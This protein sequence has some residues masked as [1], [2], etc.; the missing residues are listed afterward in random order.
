MLPAGVGDGTVSYRQSPQVLLAA[1]LGLCW[2]IAG[3]QPASLQAAEPRGLRKA[4]S[5]RPSGFRSVLRAPLP[6]EDDAALHDIQFVGDR[7]GWAVGDR[8]VIWKTTDG[9]RSWQLVPSPVSCPLRSICFL[10][11]RVGW[12][13]G[14]GTLPYTRVGY[15]VLLFTR[16]GGQTW[17]ALA[18]QELP[19]LSHVQF[20]G[21]E[22]GVAVGES[23]P[24]YP[25][26]VLRT[27]DGG[28]NWQPVEGSLQPGW[29]TAAFLSPRTGIVA[30]IQ[31]RVGFA[32]Q[33][34]LMAPQIGELGLRCLRG[35][36]LESDRS[37]WLV[38][39]GGL[40]LKTISNGAV[41]QNPPT[42]LPEHLS[43]V[44]DFRAVA[45][46]GAKVWVA[47]RPGSLIW[48]SP[49]GG[50][51]W[52][53]QRTGQT[54]PI[55]RLHFRNETHGWACGGMGLILTTSDGGQ[56]W[57]AVRGGGRHAALLSISARP[58]RVSFPLLAREG[59]EQGYRVTVLVPARHDTGPDGYRALE[60]D[61]Q[62][63]EAV[64]A[65]GGAAAEIGWQFPVGIPGLAHN[66]ERLIT[67]WNS[68]TEGRLRDVF[69]GSLVSHIR[70]WRPE[71]VVLHQP[72]ADD[73]PAQVIYEAALQ[74]VNLAGDATGFIEQTELAGLEPW[75][76]KKVYVQLPDGSTGDVHIP[77]DEHL[78]RWNRTVRDGAAAG[79]S[80]L[81]PREEWQ[82][83]GTTHAAWQLRTDR[84]AGPVS[85][86]GL[87]A[88]AGRGGDFF[89]GLAIAPGSASRR[90]LLPIDEDTLERSLA[91]ARQ[92]RNVLAIAEQY[93]EQPRYAAQMVAHLEQVTR[94][95]SRERAALQL[96]RLGNGYRERSQWELV[97]AT[98]MELVEKYPE[99]PVAV[100]AMH[101]LFCFWAG[102]EP[103]YQRIR[104]Q[105][106]DRKTLESN[107]QLVTSSIE[108]AIR[109]ARTE[110]ELR[111]G[112]APDYGPDPLSLIGQNG[113]N[114][115]IRISSEQDWQT[116]TVG[117]WHDQALKMAGL[118]R[119]RSLVF[120]RTP[121]MQFPLASLM[122][123]RGVHR[124]ADSVFRRYRHKAN[125][126]LWQQTAETEVWLSQPVSEPPRP[127]YACR[128]TTG[129]PV[130]DGVLSDACWVNAQAM[131]LSLDGATG[132][133]QGNQPGQPG[134]DQP[135]NA[136]GNE[137][138]ALAMM[139]YDSEFL[140]LAL[141]IP[142][143]PAVRPDLPRDAG[144][145]HDADLT[146]F[147]RVQLTLDVDRDY[148]TWYELEI[149]QRGFTA[150]RCWGDRT[151]DPQWYVAAAGDERYWRVEVAIPFSELMP[152]AP[153]RKDVWAMSLV[154]TIPAVGVESW[155]QPASARPRPETFGLLRFD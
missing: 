147:D 110:P 66:R 118:L 152:Q 63:S 132:A 53:R 99:Q 83:H 20:F 36:S 46:R 92:Q 24:E 44:T 112:E 154:R 47:G 3:W 61:L 115:Q 121:E 80:R 119:R 104:Q 125:G 129:R 153:A 49:D 12:I 33:D 74:A 27:V 87:A 48:H 13:A 6:A 65:A 79:F 40:V 100:E 77:P 45:S 128:T 38:G 75:A 139:S 56:S 14:G 23:T 35:V 95:L 131:R 144:R 130:L 143:S 62:L 91:V 106:I 19:R 18:P 94:G 70:S 5:A 135:G 101:W 28:R 51:T 137:N 113:Q 108:R 34:Q 43:D 141:S 102:A 90:E 71:V 50:H 88:R 133:D 117:H 59:G 140:Y 72:A 68:R 31:G 52:I 15:G 42:L 64:V 124:M 111:N 82:S 150:D 41:W 9:G 142:R 105:T 146:G 4:G 123:T 107:S 96:A 122:R 30:G 8:G 98:L 2:V 89:R 145:T 120:Y 16:D 29:R 109:E 25:S 57:H 73:V 136:A 85:R 138:F 93:G 76:V 148:A 26:G 134:S 1:L 58:A 97:E 126:A 60:H 116:G 21:L 17:D 78:P 67:E 103:A 37:G 54:A 84:L 55:H 39:D 10:T 127:V 151:W 114:G 155:T 81:L 69:L 7:L 32:G 86:A 22:Q 149:D 11:D